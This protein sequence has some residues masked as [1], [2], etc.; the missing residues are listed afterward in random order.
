MGISARV[1]L[2]NATLEGQ[3]L[4][5]GHRAYFTARIDGPRIDAE[6][7]EHPDSERT[8]SL[9]EQFKLLEKF[10]DDHLRG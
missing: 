4:H 8:A 6:F 7:R 3:I 5:Q 10:V 1:R 2:D 9:W